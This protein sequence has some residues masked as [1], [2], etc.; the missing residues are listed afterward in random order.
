MYFQGVMP[1]LLQ[2]F[3]GRSS[4]FMTILHRE[5]G[6]SQDP[7]FVLRKKWT[8]PK[9]TFGANNTKLWIGLVSNC[10][11]IMAHFKV[12]LRDLELKVECIDHL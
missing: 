10:L 5:G 9:S 7:K 4:Q 11:V 3:E 8:A 6:V 12:W 2:Y 1:R